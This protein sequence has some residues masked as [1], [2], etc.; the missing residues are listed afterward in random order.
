MRSEAKY[1]LTPFKFWEKEKKLEMIRDKMTFR[2]FENTF[3][4]EKNEIENYNETFFSNLEK[5]FK[6]PN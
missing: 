2:A 6:K 5:K 3:S 1:S 4:T